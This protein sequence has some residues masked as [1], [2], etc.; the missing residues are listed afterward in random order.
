MRDVE[1]AERV[2]V[3]PRLERSRVAEDP[4]ERAEL[5][6][7]ATDLGHPAPDAGRVAGHE[8][9]GLGIRPRQRRARGVIET[10]APCEHVPRESRLADQLRQPTRCP[11]PVDLDLPAAVAGRDLSLRV[12]E[13]PSTPSRGRA[14]CRDRRGTPRPWSQTSRSARAAAVDA[15][16]RAIGFVR[17]PAYSS[18]AG[19]VRQGPPSA[20]CCAAAGGSGRS[21]RTSRRADRRGNRDPD[22]AAAMLVDDL[23]GDP[24]RTRLSGSV[25]STCRMPARWRSTPSKTSVKIGERLLGVVDGRHDAA[26]VIGHGAVGQQRDLFADVLHEDARRARAPR[27]SG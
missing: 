14:G 23:G 26:D 9:A 27:G 17:S 2:V 11:Q 5:G 21:A 16:D 7:V 19:L 18:E 4:I 13:R 22:A 25:P 12:G 1:H 15:P 24:P 8:V 6:C 20:A 3:G 10:R